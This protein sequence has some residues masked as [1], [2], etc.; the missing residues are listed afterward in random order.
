MFERVWSLCVCV[1]TQHQT[2]SVCVEV[3]VCVCAHFS[4]SS[5]K[6]PLENVSFLVSLSQLMADPFSVFPLSFPFTYDLGGK[7]WE[8]FPESFISFTV[9]YMESI[10][11]NNNAHS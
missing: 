5:S 9:E 2:H 6:A 1:R 7:K 3:S 8:D 11:N 10:V 4:V